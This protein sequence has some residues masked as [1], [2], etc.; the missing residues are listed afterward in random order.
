MK[1]GFYM[2][3][4]IRIIIFP[5]IFIFLLLSIVFQNWPL[6]SGN[7]KSVIYTY[8]H[9]FLTGEIG[10][11][12]GRIQAYYIPFEILEPGDILLGGWPN[13]AYG[14]YSH[15]GLYLG[16]GEVMEAYVDCGIC[17]QPLKH[18]DEYARLCFLRVNVSPAIKK[19]VLNTA[20]SML[21][22]TFYPVAF[23][24][25]GRYFNCSS[26]IWKAYAEHGVDLDV[27]NDIWVA[28]A[29]FQ[30]SLYVKTIFEKGM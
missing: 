6:L 29:S 23:K 13:C 25:D 16:D 28:P 1:T 15:A 22:K 21:G 11:G 18:F 10:S 8:A 17:I 5:V 19:S 24:Q 12:Y 7:K 2:N 26:F 20:G 3:T 9:S 4:K 30:E 27:N 14:K